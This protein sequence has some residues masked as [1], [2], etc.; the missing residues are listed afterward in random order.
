TGAAAGRIEGSFG[1]AARRGLALDHDEKRL[2]A[3]AALAWNAAPTDTLALPEVA[4]M[5][6]LPAEDAARDR[7]LERWLS[8][9]LASP[10][11][12]FLGDLVA[13]ALLHRA[14][15][16]AALRDAVRSRLRATTPSLGEIARRE[17]R[18]LG[19]RGDRAGAAAV[20]W[21]QL[22]ADPRDADALR[23]L[24]LVADALTGEQLDRLC[25]ALQG[26]E[27]PA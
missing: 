2:L 27:A 8:L 11:H 9:D 13:L 20:L 24:V 18:R 10:G 19:E 22:V 12:R 1:L 3:L 17:A 4:A 15:E 25:D 26:A 6:R 16:H 5:T 21:A 23:A 14:P 7:E